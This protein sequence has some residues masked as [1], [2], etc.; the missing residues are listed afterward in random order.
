MRLADPLWL[1]LGLLFVPV[2][3]TRA[4][5]HL[6]YSNLARFGEVP[7]R[8][9][10]WARLPGWAMGLGI[11]L[12]LVALARPQWGQAVEWE[13]RG[14]RDIVLAMD[15]SASMQAELTGGGGRKIDLAKAAALRFV[16]RRHGDRLGL[17]VFGSE[18]YG[19]WPLSLDVNVIREKIQAVHADLGGTDLTQPLEKALGHLRELGQST[20]RAIILV[21]DGEAPIPAPLRRELMSKVTAMDVRVYL[22]GIGV[23][24]SADIVDL[25]RQSGGRVFD[26]DQPETFGRAFEEI[27]RLEPSVVVLE[28][29]VAHRELYPWF[30]LGGLGS[31]ALAI[32]GATAAPRIP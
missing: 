22:L 5:P 4:R 16:E 2:L 17:L 15:L 25:V 11:G 30:A 3:L 26:V 9:P 24:G 7:P 10:V 12:L 19:S 8:V 6:G 28:K 21:T 23:T 1:L 27:D 18:T 31:L 20:A 14:A 29:R 13:R 32:I